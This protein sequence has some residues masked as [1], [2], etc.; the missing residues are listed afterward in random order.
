M[1]K[2]MECDVCKK[3]FKPDD[4]FFEREYHVYREGKNEISSYGTGETE[5]DLCNECYK[6]LEKWV[7]WHKTINIY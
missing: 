2:A 3:L 5:L 1:G 7:R 6:D 4:S